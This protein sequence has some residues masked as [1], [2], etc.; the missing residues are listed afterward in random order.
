M[1]SRCKRLGRV[2]N[3]SA[4][5]ET[6]VWDYLHKACGRSEWSKF[7]VQNN[8]QCCREESVSSLDTGHCYRSDS[9]APELTS[10]LLRTS[11]RLGKV[12]CASALY[13]HEMRL[14]A[15]L[16]T[17]EQQQEEKPAAGDLASGMS[18]SDGWVRVRPRKTRSPGL[19]W[20]KKRVC[21]CMSERQS[22]KY[23]WLQSG[24]N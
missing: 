15:G 8:P 9:A 19:C 6:K 5:M 23:M 3:K 22:A 10:L 21:A 7:W 4:S 13:L 11:R 24:V 17:E 18:S 20:A 16:P 2:A 12:L 14:L 1:R